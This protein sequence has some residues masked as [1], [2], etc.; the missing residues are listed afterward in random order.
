MWI[1]LKSLGDFT[2]AAFRLATAVEKLVH[3]TFVTSAEVLEL[4]T[5]VASLCAEFDCRASIT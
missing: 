2:I 5:L 4:F 3:Q 1:A